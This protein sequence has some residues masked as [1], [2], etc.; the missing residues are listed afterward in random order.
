MR[1]PGA[2]NGMKKRTMNKNLLRWLSYSLFFA[3]PILAATTCPAC[4]DSSITI[5]N[6]PPQSGGGYQVFALNQ[7][8]KLTGYFYNTVTPPHAFVYDS[9]AVSDLGTLGGMISVGFAINS[10]GQAAGQADTSAQTHAFLFSSGTLNDLGTLGGS[11]S[12]AAALNENGQVVGE[13]LTSGDAGPIAFLY[14]NGSMVSLG[15]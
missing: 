5:T 10:E 1:K 11:Y 13:S 3:M 4:G 2:I 12:S 8:G 6:L 7:N 14:V 9:G 15:N